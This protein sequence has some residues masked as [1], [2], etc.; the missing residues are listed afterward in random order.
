VR[1]A[2]PQACGLAW[3]VCLPLVFLPLLPLLLSSAITPAQQVS[4]VRPAVLQEVVLH[5]R[6][7]PGATPDRASLTLRSGPLQARLRIVRRVPSEGLI[8]TRPEVEVRL[9]ERPVGQL[10]GNELLSA[11][12]PEALLQI[13]EL[14]PGNPWPEVLLSSFSGGAHCCNDIT[15]LSSDPDGR[16][17]RRVSLGPFNGITRG[18]SDPLGSGRAVLV[19]A[20]NRFLYRFASYAGS[21]APVQ[22]WRLE[23]QR[24]VDV[25]A[26]PAWL[27][28][29]RRRLQEMAAW[30]RGPTPPEP[31]GFLAAY[32][33]TKAR[34]GEFADGWQRML[35]RH[36][37]RSTWGLSS[38]P[39]GYDGAGRCSGG[40]R[41]DPD[42]PTA[43][44]R[45]L[46][47]S[48]YPVPA[49]P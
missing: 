23:G 41:L 6:A 18:A 8:A 9:G 7:D 34:V 31:N 10:V 15:V 36:D 20:D 40:E 44:R 28:L 17:W 48:G 25:S 24:F 46:A 42:F 35:L 37:P 26:E 30:F 21:A 16:R 39:G 3:V 47:A 49:A 45:F 13:V 1:Q 38:C 29:H 5:G 22:I 27:P 11:G 4:A 19:E 12:G 32:V 14:D 33:A 43:L 2:N